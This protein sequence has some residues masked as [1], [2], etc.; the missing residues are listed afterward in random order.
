MGSEGKG[1]GKGGDSLESGIDDVVFSFRGDGGAGGARHGH[2][3]LAPPPALPPRRGTNG[4]GWLAG[5]RVASG[6][7]QCRPLIIDQLCG[8][9]K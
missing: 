2:H 8:E 5:Q 1:K 7:D 3:H 6:R 4:V 9:G